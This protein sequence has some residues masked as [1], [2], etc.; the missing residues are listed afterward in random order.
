MRSRNRARWATCALVTML[1]VPA[2]ADPAAPSPSD[3]PRVKSLADCTSFDQVNK[4]EATVEFTIHNTCTIPIDCSISWRV[5][6]APDS[7]KRRAVH[8]ESV[9][10]SL[11]EG[12][13]DSADASAKPCGDDAWTIDQVEWSCMPNKE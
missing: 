4:D 2:L 3:R 5:V 7:P 10:L 13:A 6:C 11:V 8:D 12:A 1:C 9:K